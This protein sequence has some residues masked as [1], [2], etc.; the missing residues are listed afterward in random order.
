MTIRKVGRPLK[1]VLHEE[2]ELLMK[3]G[4]TRLEK[5][6]ALLDNGSSV[7]EFW[8]INERTG[9]RTRTTFAKGRKVI[10]AIGQ[11]DLFSGEHLQRRKPKV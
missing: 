10:E 11:G 7:R 8:L 9:E 6:T 5:R 2:A 1:G 4:S 3:R